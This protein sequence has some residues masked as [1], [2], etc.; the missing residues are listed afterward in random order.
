[1][2]DAVWQDAAGNIIVHIHGKRDDAPIAAIAH[3][4]EISLIVKRV[5][6]D[7]RLR[8]TPVGGLN[9]WAIGESPVKIMGHELVPGVLSI[10]AKHVSKESV[11]G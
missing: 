4:D 6:E 5:E 7:G 8:V 3:K 2:G 1:M 9:P 11:A 10:G